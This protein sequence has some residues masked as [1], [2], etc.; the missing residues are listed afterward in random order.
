MFV[1]LFF[2]CNER[3]NGGHQVILDNDLYNKFAFWLTESSYP[4]VIIGSSDGDHW[5][6]GTELWTMLFVCINQPTT[7]TFWTNRTTRMAYWYVQ[8]LVLK[9]NAKE[10]MWLLIDWSQI[11]EDWNLTGLSKAVLPTR[12]TYLAAVEKLF[13]NIEASI[14]TAWLINVLVN[15]RRRYLYEVFSHWLRPSHG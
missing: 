8:S 15:E 2:S 4:S 3:L 14:L 6:K 5:D 1:F 10:K 13:L 7:I 9:Y 11:Q 12:H